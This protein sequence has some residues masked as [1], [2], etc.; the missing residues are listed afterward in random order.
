MVPFC[1]KI[2]LMKYEKDGPVSIAYG[3]TLVHYLFEYAPKRAK[4]LYLHPK[5]KEGESRDKLIALAK[6]YKVQI[7]TDSLKIFSG[8]KEAT[9]AAA[10]FEKEYA[11]LSSSN[12]IVLVEPSNMGNL[13]TIMRTMGAYGLKDLALVGP[14]ADPYDPKTVRASMGA[15]F[16]LNIA[17]FNTIGD[18]LAIHGDH[19]LYPFMLQAK[20]DLEDVKIAEPYSLVFGNEAKGLPEEFLNMGTPLKIRQSD[21]VDSLNLDNA[22][23]IAV[24]RFQT[25]KKE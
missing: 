7:V 3:L 22:V 17:R 9:Y 2:P 13:G 20:T 1:P 23:S 6:E 15:L 8:A 18:Y 11:P 4:I 5:L 16:R 14:T 21:L 25:M 12:H 10:V 24:Y 19:H